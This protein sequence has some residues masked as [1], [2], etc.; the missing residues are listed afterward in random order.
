MGYSQ[1]LFSIFKSDFSQD[2]SGDELSP[3]YYHTKARFQDFKNLMEVKF[4]EA[5]FKM[6]GV[7]S[8]KPEL[9]SNRS[10]MNRLFPAN[11]QKKQFLQPLTHKNYHATGRKLKLSHIIN[12]QNDQFIQLFPFLQHFV[13]YIY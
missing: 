12:G 4:D 7:Q 5:M 10:S 9:S 8:K 2:K 3:L 6:E 13:L 11:Y 1:V